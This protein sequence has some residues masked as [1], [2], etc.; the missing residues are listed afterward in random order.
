MGTL[1]FD[2]AKPVLPRNRLPLVIA[3]ALHLA[4]LGSLIYVKTQPVR[5]SPEGSPSASGIA[6]YVSGPIGGTPASAPKPE[7][8]KTAL[9]TEVA[10]SAPKSDQSDGGQAVGTSGVAGGGQPGSGPV[11]IGSGGNIT[12]L[13]KVQPAYPTMYQSARMPGQVVLD[14]II[15]A[16]GTMGDVAV[17]RSTNDAFARS[18][19]DAVK[20][21]KYAPI[22][23]EAILTVTV[24]FT[25]A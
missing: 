15:H 13:R 4:L 14:A 21:W 22:G 24:N 16:D 1:L 11:R 6:A 7:P 9:K 19:V 10:K 5:V 18:A 12:L 17:L 8:K 3:G 25:M 23:F 2:D 20:Q